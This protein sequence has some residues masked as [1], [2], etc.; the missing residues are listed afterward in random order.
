MAITYYSK[1]G[2]T[3]WRPS[4]QPAPRGYTATSKPGTS[5]GSGGGRSTPSKPKTYIDSGKRTSGGKTIWIP[6]PAGTKFY[7]KTASGGYHSAKTGKTYSSATEAA[8]AEVTHA[9]ETAAADKKYY[10]DPITKV[11][12]TRRVEG[13]RAMTKSDVLG[14]IKGLPRQQ[15]AEYGEQYRQ[16]STAK[17]D[18]QRSELSALAGPI[19]QRGFPTLGEAIT[20]TSP[21]FKTF[22][23]RATI[24]A[25]P[26]KPSWLKETPSYLKEKA[27]RFEFK[28]L[29]T[30]GVKGQLYQAGAFGFGVAAGF[31]YP[32]RHPVSFVKGVYGF[33][34]GL[35]TKPFVTGAA[36]KQELVYRPSSFIGEVIGTAAFGKVAPKVIKPVTAKLPRPKITTFKVP[37]KTGDVTLYKGLSVEYGVRGKPL[38]GIAEGKIR[39][40]TPK[41]SL[42]KAT[43]PFV[44]ETPAQTAIFQKSLAKVAKPTEVT[45]FKGLL[46]ITRVTE[47][48]PSKFVQ[49][50]FIKETKSLTPKGVEEVLKFA[51]KEKAQV[52]G[53][54]AARQQTPKDLAR[55]SA[56]M[57][58]Q[59]KI[60]AEASALK[61]KQLVLK[62]QKIGEPVRIS[63]KTPTLIEVQVGKEWHHAVDIHSIEQAIAEASPAIGGEKIYG[64]QLGQKPIKIKGIETMR[65]SEQGVRK[66]GSI[67]TARPGKKIT[68]APEAHRIKDIPDWFASQ[69]TLLRSKFLPQSARL[70]KLQKL[71]SLYPAEIFKQP[72]LEQPKVLLYSPKVSVPKAYVLPSIAIY[73]SIPVKGLT[74]AF[75]ISPSVYPLK[76]VKSPSVKI[77]P[78]V[79]PISPPSMPV[80]IKSSPSK[81]VSPYKYPSRPSPRT[82]VSPPSPY[83]P[84]P[85]SPYTP[86]PPPSPKKPS[87]PYYPPKKP[88]SRPPYYPPYKPP[89]YPPYSPPKLVPSTYPKVYPQIKYPQQFMKGYSLK[90]KPKRFKY[91]PSLIAGL[92]RI[93]A[94]KKPERI[95]GLGIRPVIRF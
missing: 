18:V 71:K 62:L 37:T 34:K 29:K 66:M 36:I 93:T 61:T 13:Q 28:A 79:K 30:T 35:V 72:I 90:K 73:P 8:R 70:A 40:G 69:E 5:G 45:K 27:A 53:S 85:P 3:T 83:K 55:V 21:T 51:K 77:S 67:A 17:K 46:D 12:T 42:S 48:T 78:M 14:V 56:D 50:S 41:V 91:H 82:Y 89:Y 44:V 86:S 15:K 57:D 7:M 88:P 58:I 54:F 32:I 49:K 47:K 9:T 74:G 81:P 92:E 22:S 43:K 20:E 2:R 80:Y 84:S 76:V 10:Y 4:S 16:Y 59:L 19:T 6:A 26:P 52:Y 87:P 95:T 68:F 75:P 38:I 25:A 23:E 33:G 63:K 60:G 64:L 39:L 65:L 24:T 94:T 31:T 1:G 11:A